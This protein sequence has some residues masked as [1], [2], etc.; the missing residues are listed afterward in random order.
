MGQKIMGIYVNNRIEKTI[1][2]QKLLSKYGCSIRTRIGLHD[3]SEEICSPAGVILLDL[4]DNSEEI[5]KLKA[6]VTSI[7]LNVQMMIF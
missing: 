3:A 4:V 1:E 5:E 7:G 2:L 6:D